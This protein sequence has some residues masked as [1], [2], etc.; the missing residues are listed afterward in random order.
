[1]YSIETI[2]LSRTFKR[3]KGRLIYALRDVNIKVRKGEIF[4]LLGPNGA[5]KTTLIR[6]LATLLLPTSGK[7]YVLGY[8]VVGEA[9][10]VREVINVVSGGERSGYG[11]MTVKE[12]LWYFT[13]LYGLSRRDGWRKVRELIEL[14]GMEDFADI[15]L[16]RLSTGMIQKYNLARGLIN[17]PKVLFLDE[18]TLGLDVEVAKYI[19][20]LI[21]KLIKEDPERTIFLT[22]HYMAEAE[23]LCDRIAII[24]KG[25][26]VALGS[27]EQLKK[28]ICDELVYKLEVKGIYSKLGERLKEA[29]FSKAVSSKSD[30]TT[31]LTSLRMVLSSEEEAEEV[32]KWLIGSG[33]KVISISKVEPSLEDV[34]LKLVGGKLSEE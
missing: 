28:M 5:G 23:E 32:V 7:A 24:H 30:I 18:P 10:K 25:R 20:R 2:E 27:P 26:I 15:R 3:N 4:G 22:T 8:D 34:F 11:I 31:G 9:N 6:I 12:N 21:R 16:N 14:L 13:Q 17:D 33:Y 1:M 19:R 29:G